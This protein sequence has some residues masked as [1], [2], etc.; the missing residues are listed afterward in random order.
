MHVCRCTDAYLVVWTKK[1]I[2]YVHVSLDQGFVDEV[3]AKPEDYYFKH[4]L[5]ALFA[6]H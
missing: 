2:S 6:E 5:P 3:L 1:D 4:L